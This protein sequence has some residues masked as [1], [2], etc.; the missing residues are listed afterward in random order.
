M[1]TNTDTTTTSSSTIDFPVAGESETLDFGKKN[2]TNS[3]AYWKQT[4]AFQ[5]N[6]K[7]SKDRP[8]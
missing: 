3:L 6:H 1:A 8:R 5:T 4:N 2:E 7:L